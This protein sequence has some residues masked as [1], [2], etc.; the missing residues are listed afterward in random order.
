MRWKIVLE[1]TD[2]FGSAHRSELTI[3]KDL[4]RLS[5]SVM[6]ILQ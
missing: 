1:G 2:E 4:E 6:I 5:F 3:D